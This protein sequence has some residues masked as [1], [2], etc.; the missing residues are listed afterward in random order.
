MRLVEVNG[1]PGAVALG[2]AGSI[3]GVVSVDVAEG[4]VQAIWSV[5]NPDKLSRVLDRDLGLGF[6]ASLN[7]CQ[8]LTKGGHL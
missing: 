7:S 2:D 3:V 4:K 8:S 6:S 1:Q 5:L